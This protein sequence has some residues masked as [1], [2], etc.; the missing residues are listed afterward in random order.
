MNNFLQNI[1]LFVLDLDGVLYIGNK[2]VPEAIELVSYLRKYYKI[3]FFSNTSGKTSLQICEK[4]NRLG[5]ICTKDEV[6]TASSSTAIYL[7]ENNIDNVFVIGSDHFIN[8]IECKGITVIHN[9]HADAVVVG[10]DTEF[11]YAKIEIALSIL[12][13]GE[14]FIACNKDSYFPIGKNKYLPGCGAM[15]GAISNIVSKEPDFIVGKPNTYILEKISEAYKVTNKEMVVVGDS[16]ESDIRMALNYNCKSIFI[17]K[18]G[19]KSK[20]TV[21]LK[22]LSEMLFFLKNNKE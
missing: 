10:L 3:A 13:R 2:I 15:V 7:K 5:F 21:S 16:Y 1:K 20:E 6:F 12:L 8:E 19:Y 18:N 4:L 14:K 11:N 22:N 9:E 17:N